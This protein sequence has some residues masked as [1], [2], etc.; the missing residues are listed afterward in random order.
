MSNFKRRICAIKGQNSR[1]SSFMCG[2]KEHL[3][4]FANAIEDATKNIIIKD[5]SCDKNDSDQ[6]KIEPKKL[7]ASA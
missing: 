5:Y 6:I 2:N 1:I 3:V 7:F 4:N